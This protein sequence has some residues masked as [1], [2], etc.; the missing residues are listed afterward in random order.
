MIFWNLSFLR[1][2]LYSRFTFEEQSLSYDLHKKGKDN[3][4]RPNFGFLHCIRLE[5]LKV[6]E[7]KKGNKIKLDKRTKYEKRKEKSTKRKM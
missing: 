6:L 7:K 1:P 2:K 3:T 5:I 4:K